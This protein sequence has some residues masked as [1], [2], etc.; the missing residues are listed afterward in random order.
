MLG[1]TLTA[2]SFP[3]LSQANIHQGSLVGQ[4]EHWELWFILGLNP[5]T[6]DIINLCGD[7]CYAV[8]RTLRF[9]SLWTVL[10]AWP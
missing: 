3:S 10:R 1:A 2:F 9:E 6:Y 8:V 7:S 4:G 5:A